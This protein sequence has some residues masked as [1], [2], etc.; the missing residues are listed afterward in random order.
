MQRN[1]GLSGFHNLIQSTS[2]MAQC[3]QDA[4]RENESL[5]SVMLIA[6]VRQEFS[7]DSII[8]FQSTAWCLSASLEKGLLRFFPIRPTDRQGHHVITRQ[9]HHEIAFPLFKRRLFFRQIAIFIIV[10]PADIRLRMVLNPVA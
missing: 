5:T 7:K 1:D 6:V 4:N 3:I 10:F 8:E 2:G 9:L